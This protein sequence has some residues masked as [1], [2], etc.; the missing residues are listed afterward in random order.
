MCDLLAIMC[1]PLV[2]EP[3]KNGVLAA[4]CLGGKRDGEALFCMC[5]GAERVVHPHSSE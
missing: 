5:A 2:Y 1:D 3:L 4:W